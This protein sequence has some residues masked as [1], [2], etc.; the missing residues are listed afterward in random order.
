MVKSECLNGCWGEA[1]SKYVAFSGTDRSK[2]KNPCKMPE[3]HTLEQTAG[4]KRLREQE[5][6]NLWNLKDRLV[7][8]H[9]GNYK[10]SD[11]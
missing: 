6:E 4:W 3:V 1:Y 11:T 10:Y 5:R 8:K 7:E 9:R 2:Y